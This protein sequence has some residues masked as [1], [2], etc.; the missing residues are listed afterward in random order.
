MYKPFILPLAAQDIKDA[1]KWYNKKQKGLGKKF[2]QQVRQKVVFIRKNPLAAPIRYDQIRTAVVD[3]F[4][5]MIHYQV[6]EIKQLIIISA[7]FHTSQNPKSW[8]DR[9]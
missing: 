1:A 9:P 5:F 4:P 8:T 3:I 7:V 6:D 2:T